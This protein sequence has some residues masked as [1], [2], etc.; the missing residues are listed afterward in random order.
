VGAESEPKPSA[1]VVP[2]PVRELKQL[3]PFQMVAMGMQMLAAQRQQLQ[4]QANAQLAWMIV[5]VKRAGG[6]LIL[7]PDELA[8]VDPRKD[9]LD[10]V[11]DPQTKAVVLQLKRPGIVVANQMPPADVRERLLKLA[12]AGGR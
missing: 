3:S 7:R 6:R 8:A 5:L 1:N 4:Q 10:V 2:M 9:E 11:L 12:A